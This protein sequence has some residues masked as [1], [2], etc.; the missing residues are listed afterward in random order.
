MIGWGT[1][2]LPLFDA[3]PAPRLKPQTQMILDVLKARGSITKR[4]AA[5]LGCW[6]LPGRIFEIRQ[7]YNAASVE[8]V[9]EPNLTGR[10]THDR[11]YWRGSRAA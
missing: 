8:S 1:T 2:G 4:E 5:E 6:N 3:P 11:Y 9:P 7:N 10:G